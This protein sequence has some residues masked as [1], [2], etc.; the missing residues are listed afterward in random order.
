MKT[1]SFI[2]QA[3]FGGGD[4]AFGPERVLCDCNDQVNLGSLMIAMRVWL[5]LD[6]KTSSCHMAA[7]Q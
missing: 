2:F 6:S 4:T 5:T 3:L 7:F 1:T